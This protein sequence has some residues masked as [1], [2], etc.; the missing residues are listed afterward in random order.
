M[1]IFIHWMHEDNLFTKDGIMYDTTYECI[2]QYSCKNELWILSMLVF[3][4]RVIIYR[5]INAPGDGRRKIDGIN[6]S[7]KSYSRQKCAL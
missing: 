6:E 7:D 5:Y 2:K 4:Y 3:T 1:K